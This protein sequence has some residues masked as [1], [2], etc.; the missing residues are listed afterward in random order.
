MFSH[1][2]YLVCANL[3]ITHAIINSKYV[4]EL[5]GWGY[6]SKHYKVMNI[7]LLS[8]IDV[9]AVYVWSLAPK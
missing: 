1:T 5:A 2:S 4:N 9:T 6:L 7:E 3:E 8:F